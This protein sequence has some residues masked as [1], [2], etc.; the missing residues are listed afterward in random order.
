MLFRSAACGTPSTDSSSDSDSSATFDPRDDVDGWFDSDTEPDADTASGDCDWTVVEQ[1]PSAST[2][3]VWLQRG[4][5]EARVRVQQGIPSDIYVATERGDTPVA[6]MT[7]VGTDE[8]TWSPEAGALQGDTSYVLS[9]QVNGCTQAIG[10]FHTPPADRL[11]A[12]PLEL[13]QWDVSG[14]ED[15]VGD[16]FLPL[17]EAFV[18]QDPERSG[19]W[20]VWRQPFGND[21]C[22]ITSEASLEYSPPFFHLENFSTLDASDPPWSTSLPAIVTGSFTGLTQSTGNALVVGT[23]RVELSS[24]QEGPDS[25]ACSYDPNELCTHIEVEGV[26][27]VPVGGLFPPPFFEVPDLN[28]PECSAVP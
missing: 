4:F 27:L 14:P 3:D 6:G 11:A 13:H 1:Y 18:G 25:V 26:S 23:L 2:G 5:T 7:T 24:A 10:Q 15:S 19:E 12:L 22:L 21:S 28:L 16:L 20:S 9:A 8:S 17:F